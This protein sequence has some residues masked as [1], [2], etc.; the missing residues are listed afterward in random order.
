MSTLRPLQVILVTIK[1]TKGCGQVGDQDFRTSYTDSFYLNSYAYYYETLH[2]LN[3]VLD[4]YNY[5]HACTEQ[6]LLS[7]STLELYFST[8]LR[9]VILK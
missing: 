2:G 5:G 7:L 6:C 1:L 8:C 4:Y 9:I 3:F